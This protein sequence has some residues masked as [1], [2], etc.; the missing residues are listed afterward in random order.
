MLVIW[1]GWYYSEFPPGTYAAERI[2]IIGSLTS[3]KTR[4]TPPASVL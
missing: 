2:T 4:A 3:H 1:D